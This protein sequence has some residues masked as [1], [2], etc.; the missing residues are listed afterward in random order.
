MVKIA[1]LGVLGLGINAINAIRGFQK[2][3]YS[4]RVSG[5]AELKGA[6]DSINEN[7]V[8]YASQSATIILRLFSNDIMGNGSAFK[9]WNNYLEA[10]AFYIGIITLLL[11]PQLFI[12][13]D[14]KQ[15]IIHGAFIA[16]WGFISFIPSLRHAFYLFMGDYFRIGLDFIVPAVLLFYAVFALHHIIKNQKINLIILGATI[17]FLLLLL[18]FPY[19][20]LQAN[21]VDV[22]LQKIIAL[23][24]LALGGTLFFVAH[25]KLGKQAQL[26]LLGLIIIEAGY[27]AYKTSSERKT[28]SKTEYLYDKFGY[29]DGTRKAAN[30]LKETDPTFFRVEKDYKSSNSLHASLN[31]GMAQEYYGTTSYSSFNQLNYIRFMEEAGLI[32][33]GDETATRWSRG[34]RGRPILQTFGNVKY[35]FSNAENPDFKK[36]G[37]DSIASFGKIQVLKNRFALPLGFTYDKYISPEEFNKLTAFTKQISFLNGFVLEKEFFKGE[38]PA[39]ISELQASDT[40]TFV[41]ERYFNFDY[42]KSFTDSLKADSLTVTNF[43]QSEIE[44]AITLK[45]DKLLF[46]TIPF[47]KGWG[48]T[49]NG[50]KKVL[51][52]V[53]F[54]FS[55][56][57]LPK[58]KHTI[59]LKYTPQYY[60]LGIILSS[61]FVA[62]FLL[63]LV[64]SILRKRREGD[65]EV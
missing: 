31:E 2:M 43:K 52:R 65:T 49:V 12:F 54:G 48:I 45:K 40:T 1:G 33:K 38:V 32:K 9:G 24:I 62:V 27:F 55:G 36:F 46:F 3:F 64:L 15:K 39:S 29:A 4:P 44:G 26:V 58:G 21:A 41:S 23:I 25:P 14:K 16:T 5:N 22:G 10:P 28:F 42:Y 13:L 6:L 57:L 19:S 61:S 47:D 60:W 37:F 18:F 8:D 53:N 20:T 63:I 59:I 51:S 50:E 35:N 56:I 34:F 30:Y 11:I 7:A 17:T